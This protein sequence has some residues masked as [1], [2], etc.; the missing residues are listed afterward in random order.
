MDHKA[1]LLDLVRTTIRLKHYSICTEEAYLDWIKRFVLFHDKRHPTLMAAPE[2]RA[3]LSHRAL[4]RKVAASTQRQA[5]SAI[6][7][8]Y[9]EVLKQDPGWFGE[10][11]QAKKPGRLP[12]VL[13]RAEVRAVLAHLDG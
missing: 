11:A 7:F 6:V 9:R 3:F 10:I 5:L 2:I 4:E 13:S 1:K 8:L 12:V